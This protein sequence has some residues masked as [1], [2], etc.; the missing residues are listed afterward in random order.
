MASSG[1][2]VASRVAQARVAGVCGGSIRSVVGIR[3]PVTLEA[4]A[5]LASH[6]SARVVAEVYLRLVARAPGHPGRDEEAR[7]CGEPGLRFGNQPAWTMATGAPVR[8]RLRGSSYF[9]SS[10]A[11]GA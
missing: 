10:A 6:R 3:S 5:R 7:R 11:S 9:P 1:K 2:V 4:H 8:D